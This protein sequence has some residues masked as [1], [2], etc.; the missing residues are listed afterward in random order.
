MRSVSEVAELAGVTVRTLHHYDRIG[1]LVPQGRTEAGYR[2][3]DRSDL[4]R[5]QQ[6]MFWRTLEF[7]L[8][9]IGD[10]LDDPQYDRVA[11]LTD[12]WAQ[13]QERARQWTDEDKARLVAEGVA[14]ARRMAAAM[15][16]GVQPESNRA[17]DL[18]EQARTSI[19]SD[20]Y[21]CDH[22][23]FIALGQMYV[24]DAR[25]TAYYGQHG[26]GLA[27]W[28]RDAIVANAHRNGVSVA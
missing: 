26:E 13:S 10:L 21:D 8:R 17:M 23:M 9:R 16:S 2:M 4:D 25:F 15:N 24:D 3:Y 1:L 19:N 5:L 28:F 6:I 14:H 22:Q 7:D 12:Q 18:A 20:L 27:A 11:A